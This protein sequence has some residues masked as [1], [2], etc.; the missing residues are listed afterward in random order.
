VKR[1][2]SVREDIDQRVAERSGVRGYSSFV[3][4][5]LE[6]QLQLDLL[7]DYISMAVAEHGPVSSQILA[8]V[9][10]DIEAAKARR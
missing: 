10:A 1:S 7:D 6:T 2:I 8:R 5:A 9:D 3:N 4:R